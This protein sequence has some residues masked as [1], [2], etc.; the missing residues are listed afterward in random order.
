MRLIKK[1]LKIKGIFS[2]IYDGSLTQKQRNYVLDSFN[3][4]PVQKYKLMSSCNKYVIKENKYR[5]LIIQ[6][7]AGGVGLNLQKFSDVFITSPD[8]NP[9]NEIQ[10][11]CRAHRIGQNN[12][13]KVHKYTLR[14]N[15]SY[16]VN[17]R[18]M[19]TID[20]RI[21][22]KQVTKRNTMVSILE[23][24]TLLFNENFDTN[25]EDMYNLLGL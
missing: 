18:N 8:W 20:E 22:N 5:V 16:I 25:E 13:V 12:R 1:E 17:S 3:N 9:S 10:A 2:K 19:N 15:P 6:I 7:K 21:L 11:I 23:D 14:Y 24:E 4:D